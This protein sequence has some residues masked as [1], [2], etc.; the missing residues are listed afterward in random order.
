M[1]RSLTCKIGCRYT[2]IALKF[3]RCHRD[4][5]QISER[6][7]KSK[8]PSYASTLNDKTSCVV[9]PE[10]IDSN[11]EL[12]VLALSL[13]TICDIKNGF[14]YIVFKSFSNG[15]RDDK[16]AL[17]QVVV[18]QRKD[19]Q[20]LSGAKQPDEY[21]ISRSRLG[22]SMPLDISGHWPIQGSIRYFNSWVI[23]I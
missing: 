14:G 21:N 11:P 4:A 3:G 16:A 20:P 13:N 1:V 12:S 9:L 15:L 10:S 17:V 18:W 6:W 2:R 7:E 22:Q 5:C 19:D 8:R 23:F